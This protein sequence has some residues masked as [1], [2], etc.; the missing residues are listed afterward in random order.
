MVT[1]FLFNPAFAGLS[2]GSAS[3]AD[4]IQAA[5]ST[6]VIWRLVGKEMDTSSL[7]MDECFQVRGA[8]VFLNP[9]PQLPF[10]KA[11]QAATTWL[12]PHVL[13]VLCSPRQRAQVFLLQ[14]QQLTCQYVGLMSKYGFS[15]AEKRSLPPCGWWVS[16]LHPSVLK[17]S[18]LLKLDYPNLLSIYKSR[19]EHTGYFSSKGMWV[20]E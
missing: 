6:A 11:P 2:R 4:W 7:K 17:R 1:E 3:P 20:C 15:S 13:F 16:L 8:G 9:E 18:S 12:L 14:P 19:A 5:I 10:K